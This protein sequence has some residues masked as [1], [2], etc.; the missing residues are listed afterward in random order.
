MRAR[1]GD[2]GL[3]LTDLVVASF[4]ALEALGHRRER[5]SRL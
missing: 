3:G 4:D 2:V 1:V 5:S